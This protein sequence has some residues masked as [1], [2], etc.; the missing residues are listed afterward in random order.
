VCAVQ[1]ADAVQ[2]LGLL[3]NATLGTSQS[4]CFQRVKQAAEAWAEELAIQKWI[5]NEKKKQFRGTF[6]HV[7]RC[8]YMITME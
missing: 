8:K 6:S 7:N 1:A 5:N 3:P 4:S 2:Q